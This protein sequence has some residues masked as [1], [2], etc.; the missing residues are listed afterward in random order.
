MA[1]WRRV[2]NVVTCATLIGWLGACTPSANSPLDEEKEPYFDQGRNRET[3][4]DHLGAIE[5]YHRALEVNPRSSAAHYRLGLL[6]ES[7]DRNPAAAIYHFEQFLR[8]RPNSEQAGLIRQHILGCKQELAK[9]VSL[10]LVSGEMKNQLDELIAKNQR[11]AEENQR[12]AEENQRLREQVG[13]TQSSLASGTSPPTFP[14]AS[15]ASPPGTV[16]PRHPAATSVHTVQRG[17]TYFSIA[18]RYGVSTAALQAAN[19]GVN[20][21]RLN[22]GQRLNIPGR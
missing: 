9:E 17:D 11:L 7:E 15:S 1:M 2:W 12:L 14:S 21:N 22:V 13:R 6:Y 16:P 10:G 3:R 5:S 18:K 4:Y 8:L 20:P 19:P